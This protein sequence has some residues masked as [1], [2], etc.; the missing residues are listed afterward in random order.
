MSTWNSRMVERRRL[1]AWAG[2][3]AAGAGAALMPSFGTRHG[4]SETWTIWFLDPEHGAGM[5]GCPVDPHADGSR[6]CHACTACHS[7][8]EN[9]IFRTFDIANQ[10]RAHRY[11]KCL[12]HSM[13]VTQR[14][15]AAFFGAPGG[16]E[17]DAFDKRTD[18]VVLPQLVV[19]GL[20]KGG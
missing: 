2:A 20:T 5:P 11:C 9:K 10:R 7:H 6:S 12:V 3:I 19:P 18:P 14:E 15:Y 1:L 13:E 8:A 4:Q 16:Q 17:R